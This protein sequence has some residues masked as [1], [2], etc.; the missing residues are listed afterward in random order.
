MPME[1]FRGEHL[2]GV[3]EV[4]HGALVADP[5]SRATFV[6]KV[7]LDP[8]FDPDGAPVAFRDSRIAGF[9]LAL[10]RR[11]PLEDAPPDT[12]SGYITL[13]AV[14]PWARRQGIGAEL[15]ARAEGHL[16]AKGCTQALI[17]PYAPGYFTPGVDVDA[18]ADALAFLEKCGYAAF[19]R[20]IAMETDLAGASASSA[21]GVRIPEWVLQRERELAAQGTVIEPYTPQRLPALFAF[22][23]DHFPGDWQRFARSAADRIEQ[24]EPA[25]RLWIAATGDRVVGYSH[26]EVER[27]GPIGVAPDWRGRGI[28][29]VLM[30]RT[31][32]AM[33]RQS[34]H[35][36]WFMW[37]DERTAERL[38]RGAGFRVTRRFAVLRKDIA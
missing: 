36:A 1:S 2:D 26:H 33:R 16:R 24:G 35:T 30:Y 10:V 28:G 12:G 14:A 34:L 8:N 3:M 20:P 22:L 4:L 32:E 25:T 7:L 18:Y 6:R 13:I 31:L 17:S 9:A 27:F 21:T 23:R 29:H 38:Y 5:M 19:S 37:T 15:L 11:V